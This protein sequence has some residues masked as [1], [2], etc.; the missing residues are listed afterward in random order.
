MFYGM[1]TLFVVALGV[2]FT[3]STQAPGTYAIAEELFPLTSGFARM[4]NISYQRALWLSLP[5]VYANFFGFVW[6]YGRQMSA[7][8][9]SGLLPEVFAWVSPWTDTPYVASIVGTIASFALAMCAHYQ[10][11]G[12]LFEDQL[13]Q[14]YVLASYIVYIL[15]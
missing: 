8:A 5:G 11:F 4:F 2:I 13:M 15:W 10:V 1:C 7:M 12:T 3:V 6:A 14:I 9:K